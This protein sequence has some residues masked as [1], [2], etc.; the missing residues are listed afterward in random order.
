MV[1]YDWYLD[2]GF[3]EQ[4][5]NLDSHDILK[6]AEKYDLTNKSDIVQF[7]YEVIDEFREINE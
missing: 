4:V 7:A 3:D 5:S 1:N 6:M 2:Q